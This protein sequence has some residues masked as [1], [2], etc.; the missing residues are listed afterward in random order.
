MIKDSQQAA[1]HSFFTTT[2]VLCVYINYFHIEP[3][4]DVLLSTHSLTTPPCYLLNENQS[5]LRKG[6]EE[7]G[8]INP[9]PFTPNT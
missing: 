9:A 8:T 4:R 3:H 7:R 5:S 1:A 6:K 2:D